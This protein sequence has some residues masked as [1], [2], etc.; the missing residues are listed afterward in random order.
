M[1]DTPHTGHPP[2]PGPDPL[3][4]DMVTTKELAELIGVPVA[5]LNNWRSIG[6][7]PRS[8]PV[9]SGA[10]FRSCPWRSVGGCRCWLPTWLPGERL[11]RRP[12]RVGVGIAVT[13]EPTSLT[14]RKHG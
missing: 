2:L 9:I 8:F 10:V 14:D 3:I 13:P 4:P 5:T 1:I 7:G 11:P 6:R 12:D